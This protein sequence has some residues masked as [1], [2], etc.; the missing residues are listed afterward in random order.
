MIPRPEPSTAPARTRSVAT[1]AL[2]VLGLLA[3]GACGNGGEAGPAPTR[4]AAAA[5]PRNSIV[6]VAR[7]AGQFSTLLAAVNAAGLTETLEEGGPFTVFAPTDGAFA[8]L[9]EG[10]VEALLEDPE[11]LAAILLYHVVPGEL[12]VADL[13]DRTELET[14]QGSKLQIRTT[15]QGITINDTYLLTSDVRAA[16]GI[17]HVI[18]SVLVPEGE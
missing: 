5:A 1:P 17:I 12:T 7:V 14:A 15:A 16:N 11:A 18:T 4:D 9:P 6:A 10:T 3:L 2:C 8:N 13:R